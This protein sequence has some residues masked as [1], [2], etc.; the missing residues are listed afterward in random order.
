MINE[1]VVPAL[2]RMRRFGPNRDGRF[3]RLWWVQDGAPPHRRRTVT[4][5][6]E[7]LFGER[8]LALN[9]PVEWPPRSP[10]LTPLDFFLWWYLKSNVYITPPVNLGDLQERVSNAVENLRQDRQ[11]IRRSVFGMLRRAEL[12]LERNGGHVED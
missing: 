5:R 3:Q 8:V 11:M 9:H 10:D 2:R 4:G 7:E 1:Q 12:C 6:L